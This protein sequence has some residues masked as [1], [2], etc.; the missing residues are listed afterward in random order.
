MSVATKISPY[1]AYDIT[2]YD[3]VTNNLDEVIDLVK[4]IISKPIGYYDKDWTYNHDGSTKEILK[5]RLWI[6]ESNDLYT[7]IHIT[8]DNKIKFLKYPAQDPKIICDI[9]GLR[10]I[11]SKINFTIIKYEFKKDDLYNEFQLNR[12]LKQI[13]EV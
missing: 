10:D 12:H 4:Y 6:K 3:Y 7:A 1:D 13:M 2:S 8:E 11:L 5:L 9:S